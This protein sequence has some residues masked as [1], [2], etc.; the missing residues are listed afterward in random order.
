LKYR[1]Q[2]PGKTFCFGE[3]AA[4]AKG[5]ALLITTGPGFEIQ[6]EKSVEQMEC[7]VHPESP[8]GRY[9]QLHIDFFVNWKIQFVDHYAGRGGF[10]ASTAQFLGL[11]LF[12]ENQT[13][14]ESELV[15]LRH[16]IWN[17][18][19]SIHQQMNVSQ[20]PS[21]YDLWAQMMGGVAMVKRVFTQPARFVASSTPWPFADLDFLIVPT[22]IKVA[23]H[24]HLEQLNPDAVEQLAEFSDE[25]IASSAGGNSKAFLAAMESWQQQL[26]VNGLVHENTQALLKSLRQNKEVLFAKGLWCSRRGRFI[27]SFYA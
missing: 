27:Y 24:K 19:N 5:S 14:E 21:G 8:A 25:M 22:G 4:L 1:I 15:T 6:F 18:Y 16:K 13:G 3:Y 2:I 7:P 10:G 9:Y 20:L 26:G 17:D 11:A 23:T 12:L